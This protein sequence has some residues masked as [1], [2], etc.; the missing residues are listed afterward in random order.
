MSLIGNT[1]NKSIQDSKNISSYD[2]DLKILEEK[3]VFTNMVW[4]SLDYIL[5]QRPSDTIY[6]NVVRQH[7]KEN[8]QKQLDVYR[9]FIYE[10]PQ[11]F[12]SA[13]TLNNLKFLYGKEVTQELFQPMSETIKSSQLGQNISNFIDLSQTPEINDKYVDFEL[14]NQY[15]EKVK[16]SEHLGEYTLIEFW[17]SWCVPCRRSNPELVEIHEIFKNRGLN[18]IGVS[19]DD[20]KESWIQAIEEDGLGWINVSDLKGKENTAALK[21]GITGVPTNFLINNQGIIIAKDVDIIRLKSLI[22]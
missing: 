15:G 19:V 9:S 2:R 14:Q 11:S 16:L 5:R 22:N 13:E 17:A 7:F 3:L 20:D 8:K 18:I 1:Q 6:R 4:D 21:Y 12:V 10:N